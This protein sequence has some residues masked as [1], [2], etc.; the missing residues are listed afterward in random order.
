MKK[1]FLCLFTLAVFFCGR[2]LAQEWTLTV[3]QPVDNQL[4]YFSVA[5]LP[6]QGW[7]SG[8][9]S[10]HDGDGP[11]VV[12][13]SPDGQTS[14]PWKWTSRDKVES[15]SGFVYQDGQLLVLTEDDT[16][17]TVYRA[18][19][20]GGQLEAVWE[21]QQRDMYLFDGDDIVCIGSNRL[22]QGG[23]LAW[24]D[25]TEFTP[26]MYDEAGKALFAWDALQFNGQWVAGTAKAKQYNSPDGGRLLS[27]G[28]S[29][30][31][32][33]PYRGD[34]IIDLSL[35]DGG[36]YLTTA[37]GRE[38][39]TTDLVN[40]EQTFSGDP[41]HNLWRVVTADGHPLHY[42]GA[43]SFWWGGGYIKIADADFMTLA[44]GPDGVLG[45]VVQIKGTSY[46]VHALQE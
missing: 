31:E 19:E 43:G 8:A 21:A 27:L 39:F 6:D 1:Y 2:V 32:I 12:S 40:F 14:Q 34:G 15:V 23:R 30:W 9:Y 25:G 41:G 16:S 28:A 29:G 17:P 3:G 11:A 7:V 18:P 36:L 26:A 5:Y 4:E 24:L 10:A 42:S 38:L 35:G 22:D 20:G 13:F 37:Q 44:E 46:W 45:G 33:S